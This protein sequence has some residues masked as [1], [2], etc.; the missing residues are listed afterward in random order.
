MEKQPSEKDWADIDKLIRKK[1][2]LRKKVREMDVK[3]VRKMV[4]N[5]IDRKVKSN[6]IRS[7][8][9]HLKSY[10]LST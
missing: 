8:Y 5:L 9:V 4:H 1:D 6:E 7:F 3:E 2:R 10:V